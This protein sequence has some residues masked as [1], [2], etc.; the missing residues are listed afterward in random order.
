MADL[1]EEDRLIQFLIGLDDHYSHLRDQILLMEPLPNIDK[2]YFMISRIIR[3]H[4]SKR[5]KYLEIANL[6]T[7]QVDS[8]HVKSANYFKER[9]DLK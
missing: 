6:S 8:R 3:Q 9:G 5:E 7:R 2:A 4:E 1:D